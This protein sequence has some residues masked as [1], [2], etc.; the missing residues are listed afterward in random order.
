MFRF[1]NLNPSSPNRMFVLPAL[2]IESILSRLH[3]SFSEQDFKIASTRRQT[4]RG[5]HIDFCRKLWLAFAVARTLHMLWM[6]LCTLWFQRICGPSQ[7]HHEK[8]STWQLQLGELSKSGNTRVLVLWHIPEVNVHMH[9]FLNFECMECCKMSNQVDNSVS[10]LWMLKK[11]QRNKD[12]APIDGLLHWFVEISIF[13]W[14][15]QHFEV[16]PPCAML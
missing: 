13:H 11:C 4:N 8:R 15:Y 3:I 1:Q 12:T 2:T 14:Q 16:Q 6:Y 10:K 5:V 7:V 9:V